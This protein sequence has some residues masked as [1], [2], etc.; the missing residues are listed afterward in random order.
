MPTTESAILS[1]TETRS[2]SNC[3]GNFFGRTIYAPAESL[4]RGAERNRSQYS[5]TRG[6]TPGLP[7]IFGI[8]LGIIRL[9]RTNEP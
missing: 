5:P 8:R 6:G 7:L 9:E 2:S 3:H 4:M 1:Q